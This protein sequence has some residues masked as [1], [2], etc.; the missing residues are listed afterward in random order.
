MFRASGLEFLAEL[1]Q[2]RRTELCKEVECGILVREFADRSQQKRLPSPAP[3][4]LPGSPR[5]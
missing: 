3:G 1:P 5:R 2:G 4:N